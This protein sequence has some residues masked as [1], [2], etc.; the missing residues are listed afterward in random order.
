[1]FSMTLAGSSGVV[2]TS[3]KLSKILS[4]VSLRRSD[5]RID[6][7]LFGLFPLCAHNCDFTGLFFRYCIPMDN[8]R[9]SLE[10]RHFEGI[11]PDK[12]G[13]LRCSFLNWN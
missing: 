5:C 7:T 11:C 9:P 4:A 2:K 13:M 3:S 8:D 1:M 12:N 10:L 6:Y